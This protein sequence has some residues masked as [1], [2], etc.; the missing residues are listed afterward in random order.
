MSSLID[1][2]TQQ[3]EILELATSL[4]PK[5]P[6]DFDPAKIAYL[7]ELSESDIQ[8]LAFPGDGKARTALHQANDS[9]VLAKSKRSGD[10]LFVLT[11]RIRGGKETAILEIPEAHRSR[12]WLL[13][14]GVRDGQYW[15]GS[16]AQDWYDFLLQL[17][18]TSTI[19]Y[20]PT[21]ESGEDALRE[22][23]V[24]SDAEL[25]LLE[26]IHLHAI[27]L[28]SS[29]DA[30]M[31]LVDAYLKAQPVKGRIQ[32]AA[33]IQRAERDYSHDTQRNPLASAPGSEAL[34]RAV[35]APKLRAVPN[36]EEP[37]VERGFD[38]DLEP[39]FLSSG[40]DD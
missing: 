7:A 9:Y 3:R 5:T 22:M 32:L 18:P 25:K 4:L 37:H 12:A 23:Y 14:E 10:T 24:T 35:P 15:H 1:H 8:R 31:G 26:A 17:P 34:G 40:F 2:G 28:R 36:R 6:P 38:D 39:D 21:W 33:L 13:L 19:G 16:D 29:G 20:Y 30:L 11:R 27:F